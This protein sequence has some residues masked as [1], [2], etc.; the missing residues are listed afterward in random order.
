MQTRDQERAERLMEVLPA[1]FT[2]SDYLDVGC[3][4]GSITIAVGR[5]VGAIRITGVDIHDHISNDYSYI[6]VA[7]CNYR[8]PVPDASYDLITCFVSIHHFEDQRLLTEIARVLRPN[9]FLVIREH[10][11]DSSPDTVPYLEMVHWV[12][13]V[14]RNDLDSLQ[15]YCGFFSYED[16]CKTLSSLGLSTQAVV[17]YPEPNPQ[18][19]YHASFQK[20]TTGQEQMVPLRTVPSKYTMRKNN[21]HEWIKQASAVHQGQVERLLRKHGYDRNHFFRGLV[22][23]RSDEQ[24]LAKCIRRYK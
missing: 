23:T 8:L 18:K 12:D 7:K 22:S 17:R 6:N 11:V 13:S 15:Q 3:G 2:A 14:S 19:L 20:K 16:I 9:G 21:L 10:D 4:D 5:R 24:M 1:D